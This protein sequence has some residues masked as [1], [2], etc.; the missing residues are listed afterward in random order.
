MNL[1][2]ISSY[3]IAYLNVRLLCGTEI[4]YSSSAQSPMTRP[5]L[6]SLVIVYSFTFALAALWPL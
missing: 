1:S 5:M 6:Y 2:L 3:R 4:I